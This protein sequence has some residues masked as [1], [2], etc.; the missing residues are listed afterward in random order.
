V[1][2]SKRTKIALGLMAEL[3]GREKRKPLVLASVAHKL[4]TSGSYLEAITARLRAAGLVEAVR[5]PGGGYL[6]SRDASE[7]SI[8]EI[9]LTVE[10][11]SH[12]FQDVLTRRLK[13]GEA[14]DLTQ[15]L[16]EKT[17]SAA[18]TFLEK[19]RLSSLVSVRTDSSR[20]QSPWDTVAQGNAWSDACLAEAEEVLV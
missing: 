14:D 17:E 1:E 10:S 15:S 3:A 11:S 20:A 19:L 9:I 4:D 8:L 18:S 12:L 7:I 2:M 5:G 6:L 13:G 16:F